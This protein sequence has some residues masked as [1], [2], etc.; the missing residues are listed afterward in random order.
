ML[1]PH[2]FIKYN[3]KESFHVTTSSSRSLLCTKL[4]FFLQQNVC[5]LG[6]TYTPTNCMA[7]RAIPGQ[8][9]LSDKATHGVT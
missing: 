8:L 9:K 7:Q 3:E 5:E 2:F 6:N 4:E 1:T